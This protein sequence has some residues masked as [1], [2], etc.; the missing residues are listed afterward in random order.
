MKNVSCKCCGD[1]LDRENHKGGSANR[2]A[3]Y[4]KENKTGG[5]FE[6]G[7]FHQKCIG[8][9]D[10]QEEWEYWFNVDHKEQIHYI[11]ESEL[12]DTLDEESKKR[13]ADIL[14]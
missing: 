2:G 4:R 5:T 13:L 12:I 11:K 10:D 14:Q 8:K 1:V 6:L 9:L 3:A 7:I